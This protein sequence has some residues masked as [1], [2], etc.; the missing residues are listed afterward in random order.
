MFEIDE[1]GQCKSNLFDF[2]NA[3]CSPTAF[4]GYAINSLSDSGWYNH[5]SRYSK[6]TLFSWWSKCESQSLQ[7][8][9]CV[10]SQN[11]VCLYVWEI[12]FITNGQNNIFRKEHRFGNPSFREHDETIG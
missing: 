10:Q 9:T 8:S 4:D 6:I 2:L 12:R 11:I 5:N 1:D 7:E 3:T